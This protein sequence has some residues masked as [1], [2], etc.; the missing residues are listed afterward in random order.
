GTKDEGLPTSVLHAHDAY[1]EG[2][3]GKLLV[4]LP[5]KDERD[6][7]GKKKP[8]SAIMMESF[9]SNAT[10]ELAVGKLEV[11]GRHAASALYNS[12]EYRRI[13]MR[14]LWLPLAKIQDGLGGKAKAIATLVM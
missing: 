9:E 12:A 6:V 14:F 13:P 2:S 3:N 7:K 5:L 1:I 10:G 11:V 4:V 8:R